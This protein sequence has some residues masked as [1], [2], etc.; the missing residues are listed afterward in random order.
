MEKHPCRCGC[1]LLIAPDKQ[2]ARGHWSRTSAAR[3][4]YEARRVSRLAN[5]SGLCF[6][7]CGQTTPLATKNCSAR[8]YYK[9]THVRYVL[10]HQVPTGSD[11]PQWKGGRVKSSAGYVSVM[12][13]EHPAANRDGYVLEHRYVMEQHIGRTLER[14]ESVH[15]IN[16]IRDD[17]RIENLV[18]CQSHAEHMRQHHQHSGAMGDVTPEQRSEWARAAG[19]KGGEARWRGHAARS[20]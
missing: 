12:V 1:G 11:N 9:G 10:G 4:M 16:G 13:P 7:G 14:H 6:C 2:F 18:V 20:R 3:E 19:K 5:P 17:N 8:G 15:H